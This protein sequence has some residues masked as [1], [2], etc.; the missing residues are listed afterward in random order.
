MVVITELLNRIGELERYVELKPPVRCPLCGGTLIERDGELVCSRCGYVIEE[1]PPSRSLPWD[2]TYALEGHLA[3]GRSLGDTLPMRKLTR[4][5][6]RVRREDLGLRARHLKTIV[7]AVEPHEVLRLKEKASALLK[8]Y[9][10]YADYSEFNH[11][12]GNYVGLLCERLGRFLHVFGRR[13]SSYRRLAAAI[14]VWLLLSHPERRMKLKAEMIRRREKVSLDDIAS[15][16]CLI[17]CPLINRKR[18]ITRPSLQT[19]PSR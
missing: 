17:H 18:S 8:Q 4:V 7:E 2:E 11:L 9:G 3:W 6:A 14:L 5:I 16:D 1:T 12:L 10:F 15:I 19:N 13:P